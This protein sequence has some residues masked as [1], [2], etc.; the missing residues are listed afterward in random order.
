M[1]S[2]EAGGAVM[3]RSAGTAITF[4]AITI[5]SETADLGEVKR[6]LMDVLKDAG[7]PTQQGVVKE[8]IVKKKEDDFDEKKEM[9][10]LREMM[11]KKTDEDGKVE[12]WER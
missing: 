6:V 2:E 8:L 3:P 1:W 12:P 4:G 5:V 7:Y 9:A 10:E 11:N